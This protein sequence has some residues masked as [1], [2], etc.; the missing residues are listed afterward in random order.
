MKIELL[1]KYPAGVTVGFLLGFMIVHP[2]SMVFEGLLLPA[3]NINLKSLIYAFQLHH[4]PMAL[5]FGIEQDS[6][7]RTV[8][9]AYRSPPGTAPVRRSP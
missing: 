8:R 6:E 5:F 2:L 1:E 7:F 3:I 9:P 4:L